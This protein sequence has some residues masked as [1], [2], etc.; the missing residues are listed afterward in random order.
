MYYSLQELI[1]E[2]QSDTYMLA[3]LE[4]HI[5][6]LLP[7]TLKTEAKNIKNA[8]RENVDSQMNI[9]YLLRHFC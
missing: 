6:Q 9:R 5:T 3:R 2:Y 4:T 7:E 8:K 1:K